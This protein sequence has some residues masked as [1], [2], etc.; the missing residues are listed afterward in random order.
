MLQPVLHQNKRTQDA[1]TQ[2]CSKAPIS[3]GTGPAAGS[4]A[5]Q[6][7]HAETQPADQAGL[8][9]SDQNKTHSDQELLMKLLIC[10]CSARRG[11]RQ[12]Q[13]AGAAHAVSGCRGDPRLPCQPRRAQAGGFL[14]KG[15]GA[16]PLPGRP[17]QGS[18]GCS[19]RRGTGSA[20]PAVPVGWALLS[21]AP[22]GD[23][24]SL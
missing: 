19:P 8:F 16:A 14:A 9:L 17:C 22:G 2:A 6:G 5:R 24:Q 23:K 4:A 13:E 20:L 7:S 3:P 1:L 12:T 15:P 11:E 18:W 10:A 21:R